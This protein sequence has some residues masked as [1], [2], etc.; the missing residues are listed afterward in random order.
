M[1]RVLLDAAASLKTQID[2]NRDLGITVLKFNM[3]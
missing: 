3:K 2:T 1:T